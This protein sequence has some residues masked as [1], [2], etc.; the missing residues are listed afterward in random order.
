MSLYPG[1]APIAAEL[2]L[3]NRQPFLHFFDHIAAGGEGLVPVRRRGGDRDAGL[4]GRDDAQAM[5][6]RDT[7]VGPAGERL[8]EYPLGLLHRHRL[9]GRVVDR[10]D[11]V[12]GAYGSQKHARPTP[13]RA[14]HFSQEILHVEPVPGE[15][16]HQP[17]ESGGSN[18]TSSPS[19]TI[20]S[21][22][23]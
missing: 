8:T 20:A 15:M 1:G 22:L 2:L 17:P 4:A 14:L 10:G 13:L 12:I 19:V 16:H 21:S 3:P 18:A 5:L 7:S 23:T 11:V 9:V 6:E